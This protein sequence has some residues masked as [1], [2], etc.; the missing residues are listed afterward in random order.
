MVNENKISLIL[1]KHLLMSVT[2]LF[3]LNLPF[4]CASL[5]LIGEHI[6]WMLRQFSHPL[7][8]KDHLYPGRFC[9][10]CHVS[11]LFWGFFQTGLSIKYYTCK[12]VF[13]GPGSATLLA[14]KTSLAFEKAF[15]WTLVEFAFYLMKMVALLIVWSNLLFW[16]ILLFFGHRISKFYQLHEHLQDVWQP[17]RQQSSPPADGKL[18]L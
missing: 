15:S 6:V 10:Q 14:S 11:E 18:P 17:Q 16:W 13:I 3:S 9:A 1:E 8:L 4:F 2:S 5:L 7:Y 12:R